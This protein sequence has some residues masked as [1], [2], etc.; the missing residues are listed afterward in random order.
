M[1]PRE[2][3]TIIPSGSLE[4]VNIPVSSARSSSIG[5]K[6]FT[7]ESNIMYPQYEIRWPALIGFVVNSPNPASPFPL[8]SLFKSLHHATTNIPTSNCKAAEDIFFL[9]LISV[10]NFNCVQPLPHVFFITVRSFVS[11]IQ[12][13]GLHIVIR[14]LVIQSITPVHIVQVE[15]V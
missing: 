15:M 1:Q 13:L 5:L 9:F 12:N 14:C 6:S 11:I 2:P 4:A 3:T 10:S 8:A 7:C